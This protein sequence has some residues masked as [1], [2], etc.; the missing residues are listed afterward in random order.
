MANV[1]LLTARHECTDTA[2]Q[3][4]A[5]LQLSLVLPTDQCHRANMNRDQEA[6]RIKHF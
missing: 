3:F 1:L 6:A 2:L 5:N 4:I